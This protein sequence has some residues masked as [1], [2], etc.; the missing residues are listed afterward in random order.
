[1]ILR[2]FDSYADAAV[3]LSFSIQLASLVIL[4]KKDFGISAADFGSLTVEVT[5]AAALL[6]MLPMT[7]LCYIHKDVSGREGQLEDRRDLRMILACISWCM[8]FY[9]FVSRMVANYGPSQIG[10]PQPGAPQPVLSVTEANNIA[11]LCYQG[12]EGLSPSENTIFQVFALGGSLFVSMAILGA[13]AW[14]LMERSDTVVFKLVRQAS[15][16][17]WLLPKTAKQVLIAF[18]VVWSVPQLWVIIIFR[19]MQQALAVS[20]DSADYDNSWSFGQIVAVTVF[21]PVFI[22]FGFV[23][24]R[25]TP[26]SLKSSSEEENE[27]AEGTEQSSA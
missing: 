16:A 26:G 21:L 7:I 15:I 17:T 20:I 6:T 12:Q 2:S 1:M 24:L 23:Y 27:A 11:L 18:V 19:S 14:A 13:L 8:F 25:W 9:T 4:V 5:W 3:L 22:E 10:V